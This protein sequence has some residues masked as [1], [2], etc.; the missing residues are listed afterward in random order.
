MVENL[1]SKLIGNTRRAIL[2]L[3]AVGSIGFV[4]SFASGCKPGYAPQITSSPITAVDEGNPYSYNL[5]A[6]DANGDVLTAILSQTP[7]Q[8]LSISSPAIS[9]NL[10]TWI[11]SGAVPQVNADTNSADEDP[12]RTTPINLSSGAW[13]RAYMMF[14][15]LNS[16]AYNP[17]VIADSDNLIREFDEENNQASVSVSV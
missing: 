5:T 16:G 17:K 13:T 11:I 7:S 3:A 15:Y 2:I 6:T 1:V 4:S 8:W 12:K 10:T 9:N 14:T